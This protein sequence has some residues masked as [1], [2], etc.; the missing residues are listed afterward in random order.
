MYTSVNLK[1][2]LVNGDNLKINTIIDYFGLNN[3]NNTENFKI[4]LCIYNDLI[5]LK[6]V[7]VQTLHNCLLCLRLE[8]L[9]NKNYNVQPTEIYKK[10]VKNNIKFEYESIVEPLLDKSYWVDIIDQDKCK[11][12]FKKGLITEK[13]NL[14]NNELYIIDCYKCYVLM[15][16]Y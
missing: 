11:N 6:G 14:L 7:H 3:Y 16:K 9:I 15:C 8:E 10:F 12:C 1:N 4:L 2:H 5:K 13:N